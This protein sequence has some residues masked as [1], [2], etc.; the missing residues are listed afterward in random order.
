MEFN[1]EDTFTVDEYN[2]EAVTMCAKICVKDKDYTI[3]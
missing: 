1:E 2:N 3:W